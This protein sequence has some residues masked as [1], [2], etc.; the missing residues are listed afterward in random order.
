MK[1]NNNKGYII[2]DLI[3]MYNS[4]CL[5]IERIKEYEK[6]VKYISYITK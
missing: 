2:F 5:S 1:T 3:T 4:K 6:L